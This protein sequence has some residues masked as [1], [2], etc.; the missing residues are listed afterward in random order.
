MT[1]LEYHLNRYKQD[2]EIWIST[3]NNMQFNHDHEVALLESKVTLTLG[4]LKVE[5]RY[6]DKLK[7]KLDKH[8]K[9]GKYTV[10]PEVTGIDKTFTNNLWSKTPKKMKYSSAFLALTGIE[11]RFQENMID[12]MDSQY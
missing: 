1:E 12:E 6:A 10:K 9:Q 11:K 7:D 4:C 8:N 2:Y 3:F 5:R